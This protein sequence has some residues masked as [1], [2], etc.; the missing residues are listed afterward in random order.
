MD[1]CPWLNTGKN[2]L[3]VC[4]KLSETQVLGTRPALIPHFG[5]LPGGRFGASEHGQIS[6]CKSCPKEF[7]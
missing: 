4:A 1:I 6:L 7:M 3:S 2:K 5:Q